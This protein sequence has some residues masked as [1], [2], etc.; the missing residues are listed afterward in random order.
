MTRKRTVSYTAFNIRTHPH[1]SQT[2]VDL[3]N[4]LFDL[5]RQVNLRGDTY[6]ILTEIE[7]LN[8]DPLKGISGEIVKF[9]KIEVGKWFNIEKLRAAEEDETKKIT[10]PEDL[11]P[12][13]TSFNFVFYPKNHYLVIECKDKFGQISPKML[14]IYLRN[15][16][17]SEEIIEEFNTIE[18]TLV[19]RTDQ[20]E[21]VLSLK[22]ISSLEMVLR[23]PNTDGLEDLE[24]EV[25][26]RL[27]Q[28]N[29]EEEIIILKAQRGLSVEADDRTVALGHI[30]QL[31]G[32]V[33]AT[34]HD[35]NGKRVEKSTKQHPFVESGAYVP[36]EITAK[37]F[38]VVMANAIV[39]KVRRMARAGA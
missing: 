33:K 26:E 29:V 14:E 34:G 3:F 24:D 18:L 20:L 1:S 23:R 2:Y 21:S 30:A 28:Q 35:E 6:C 39:K 16:F 8:E 9:T 15:L 4:R 5:K 17:D 25:L 13:F 36:G 19:P 7:P 27:N 31:N 11:R 37:D 10:I 38:L 22:Q 12:N 32:E